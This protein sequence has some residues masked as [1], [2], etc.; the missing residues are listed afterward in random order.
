M[1]FGPDSPF[2]PGGLAGADGIDDWFVPRQ[3]PN[4]IDYPND[5]FVPGSAQ[6]DAPH[7]DDWIY[8]DGRKAPAPATA[9]AAPRPQPAAN[10]AIP[11]RAAAPPDPFAA[12][13]SLIPAS[14]AGAMAWH[15]PIFLPPNPLSPENIPASAWVTPPPIF[16]N[17]LGQFLSMGNVP[18]NLPPDDGANGLLGG[19][20]KMLAERARANDPWH[21]AANG[22]LGGIGK[23]LSAQALGSVAAAG[24]GHGLLGALANLQPTT[25]NAPPDASDAAGSQ[26]FLSLDPIGFGD[27]DPLSDVELVADK[28]TNQ[29]DRDIFIERAFGTTPPFGSTA[30]KLVPPM[31]GR[32]PP[33][34]PAPLVAPTQ[35]PSS[36][37]GLPSPSPG[38]SANS[39][40]SSGTAIGPESVTLPNRPSDGEGGSRPNLPFGIGPG[41]YA[42]R[43][44][45]AGPGQKP[46]TAQQNQINSSGQEFGRHTCGTRDPGTPSGNWIGDHQTP[47]ALN[48]P[49]QRQYF[50]PHC[51]FC[52]P[53]QGGLVRWFKYRGK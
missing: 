33:L 17:S 43:P 31:V 46:N 49:E 52:S 3:G 27:G 48:P 11:N 41:P 28:K 53:S 29:R 4:S 1:P 18:R 30:P 7:P 32:P 36:P 45:P 44:I 9:P 12:Y 26:P 39:A 51:R 21:A 19:I 5:W 6:A 13:W 22:L 50:L 40:R 24:S 23:L 38:Q 35:P 20:G 42:G 47:T 10:P 15:P 2:A 37:G 16:P 34:P 25:S 14:R 8:P